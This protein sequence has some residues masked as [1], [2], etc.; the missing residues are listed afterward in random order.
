MVLKMTLFFLSHSLNVLF[1]AILHLYF[2]RFFNHF[3]CDYGELKHR[4][5]FINLLTQGM[6]MGQSF[7]IK[8][9]GKYLTKEQVDFMGMYKFQAA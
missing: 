9:S 5:P 2:A 6:V 1:S 7:S 3:L 8:S 4:E